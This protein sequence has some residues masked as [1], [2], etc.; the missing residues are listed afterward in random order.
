MVARARVDSFSSAGRAVDWSRSCSG[1]PRGAVLF[2][3]A[4]TMGAVRAWR[5]TAGVEAGPLFRRLDRA[6]KPH[7][8]GAGA[9]AS[10]AE[11]PCSRSRRRIQLLRRLGVQQRL[12]LLPAPAK[13]A[14]GDYSAFPSSGRGN[15]ATVGVQPPP[16]LSELPTLR[17]VPFLCLQAGSE[18]EQASGSGLVRP[19]LQCGRAAGSVFGAACVSG[20]RSQAAPK[21]TLRHLPSA[22]ERLP[23]AQP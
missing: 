7:R 22:Q 1:L 16:G 5:G 3:G 23:R 18:I 4:P 19:G 20:W 2:L 9:V 10:A 15:T 11:R 17:G 13:H 21:S 8:S 12:R 14:R 6:G